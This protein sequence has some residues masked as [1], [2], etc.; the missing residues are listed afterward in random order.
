MKMS[1]R[2]FIVLLAVALLVS[3]FAFSVSADEVT[4]DNYENVLDYYEHPTIFALDFSKDGVDYA[5]E[6]MIQTPNN[7]TGSVVEDAAAPGG[8]YLNVAFKVGRPPN[9]GNLYFN[10]N[11]EDSISDF[12]I[13]M[14]V[15]GNAGVGSPSYAPKLAFIIGESEFTDVTAGS[16]ADTAILVLDFAAG[17]VK[18]SVMDKDNEVVEVEEKDVLVKGAWYNVSL[19]YSVSESLCVIDVKNVDDETNSFSITTNY[20]PYEAIS[21]VRVGVHNANGTAGNIINVA[22]LLAAGGTVRRNV[23]DPQGGIE[24]AILGMY[25]LYLSDIEKS[26]KVK[27]C[28]VINKLLQYGFSSDVD[29]VNAAID[30]LKF[31]SVTLY[32]DEIDNFFKKYVTLTNYDDKRALV[33]ANMAYADVLMNTD[34]S[35]VGTEKAEAIKENLSAFYATNE[36]LKK[37]ESDS[38]AFIAVLEGVDAVLDSTDY[39]VL[40]SF[41]EPAS[42]CDPDLTYAGVADVYASY[43][44]LEEN[45]LK[46]ANGAEKFIDLVSKVNNGETPF[47]ERYN[48]YITIEDNIFTN[49]TYPGVT[50]A[51]ALYNDVVIPYMDAEIALAENFITYVSRAQYSTYISAKQ[52]NL[53]IA[54][55]YM[56]VCQPE[57]KGVAEAKV[58][59]A[60]IVKHI[61]QQIAAANDYIAAV[62]AIEGKTGDALLAAIANAKALQAAGNVLGVDGVTEANIKLDEISTEIELADKYCTYFI[63]VVN[64]IEKAESTNERYNLIIEAKA[65]EKDANPAYPGVSDASAKLASA[66][67]AYNNEVNKVNSNYETATAVAINTSTVGKTAN[68][69]SGH[70]VALVKKLFDEE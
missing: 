31:G 5:D 19:T 64:S 57:F 51:I 9:K 48:L 54:K 17:S 41:F 35:P 42:A 44:V 18:Y 15:S 63:G 46:I 3:V 16:T 69:V 67:E 55:G 50:E 20:L 61:E 26:E 45:V 70:V 10:W 13:D 39:N 49:E 2:I 24:S 22:S 65:S 27:I 52:A 40:N 8:K 60:E 14:T 6:L 30:D 37:A 59:Y 11:A 21:N 34:L 38:L 7:V 62:N 53:D 58:L 68:T 56:D 47:M 66:I 4:I 1:K 25:D 33:D 23:T 29:E 32:S 28:S 12:Y 43:L 36:A